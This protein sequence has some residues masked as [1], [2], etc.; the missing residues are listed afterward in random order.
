VKLVVG[1]LYLVLSD[2]E[3]V[4]NASE[5]PQDDSCVGFDGDARIIGVIDWG[6]GSDEVGWVAH[7]FF[8]IFK[9]YLFEVL[10]G[11][12]VWLDERACACE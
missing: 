6:I 9:R 2:V 7:V 10:Y 4:L 12:S 11:A 5:V 8:E 3:W 1:A